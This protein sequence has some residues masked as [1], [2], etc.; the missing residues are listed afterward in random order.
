M[1]LPTGPARPAAY[2]PGEQIEPDP[3]TGDA[4]SNAAPTPAEPVAGNGIRWELAPWRSSGMLALDLREQRQGLG[5]RSRQAVLSGDID[6]ASYL[7][8]PWFV[9]LRAGVG[10]LQSQDRSRDSSGG[11]SGSTH[12]SAW[13]GRLGVSVFPASRFP[14][15]LRADVSDTRTRGD[16][17]GA[18]YRSQRLA[19]SQGWRPLVGNHQVQLNGDHSRFIASDGVS[20]TLIVLAAKSTHQWREHAVDLG[21]SLSRNTRSDSEQKSRFNALSARHSFQPH[22]DLRVE[23]LATE[24]D[25]RL[26]NTAGDTFGSDLRQLSTLAS[27][28]PREG[29]WGYR[30]GEPL[31]VGASVRWAEF[32]S[33]GAASDAS[34]Q[35]INAT[36]GATQELQR[37]W[38]LTGNAS[39][40]RFDSGAAAPDVQSAS[41]GASVAWAPSATS[42]GSWQYVPSASLSGSEAKTS[43]DA[44][45]R[46]LG[47]QAAHSVSRNVAVGEADSVTTSLTQSGALLRESLSPSTSRAIAHSASLFWQS[48]GSTMSQTFAGLTLSDSIVYAEERGRFQMVNLQLS[49]RTQLSRA[50]SWSANLTLQGTRNESSQLDPFTGQRRTLA[51]GWQQYHSGTLS[52]ENQRAFDVPRLR[53][54]ALASAN[55]QQLEQRAAGDINAPVHRISRSLEARLDYR[56]G[57]LDT[58]LTARHAE[59]DGRAVSLIHA[60]VQRGF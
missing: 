52:Y 58:R 60:R 17:L 27:W 20:D 31:Q 13:T 22:A 9:Q 16:N 33:R 8:Q 37:V 40:G 29:E 21:A 51:P 49:R 44:P 39:Y 34:A 47:L 23:T 50:S 7:W 45:R 26:R 5:Q 53:F 3:P 10:A 25:T 18:D 36:L 12:S 2:L 24:N 41:L 15:E 14:F 19:L 54:S 1:L 32:D 30:V 42:L 59:V 6:F 48:W 11:A 38:R 28:R 46:S 55:S 4:A 56:I 35:S 43:G 57:R